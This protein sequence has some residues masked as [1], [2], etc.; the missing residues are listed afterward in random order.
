MCKRHI[1][2]L[3]RP[4]D[5][6]KTEQIENVVECGYVVLQFKWNPKRDMFNLEYSFDYNSVK[7]LRNGILKYIH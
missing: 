1:Y 5:K 6:E 7:W 4:Q 3:I 2:G